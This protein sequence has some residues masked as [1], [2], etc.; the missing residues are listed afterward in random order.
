MEEKKIALMVDEVDNVATV[1]SNN[2]LSGDEIELIGS[3]GTIERITVLNDIPFGHKIALQS[4]AAG[5]HIMKYG[6]SIGAASREIRKGEYVHI[7][8]M[9]A[10]RGRGDLEQEGKA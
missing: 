8:N 9:V 1:F 3:R 2:V 10:L 5:D 7:H 6:Q 4:I